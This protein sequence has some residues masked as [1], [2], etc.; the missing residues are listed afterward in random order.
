METDHISRLLT[1]DPLMCY[2]DM[3]VCST[4]DSDQ[5]GE[6]LV[7]M[8]VDEIGE[9]FDPHGQKPQHTEFTNFMNKHCSQ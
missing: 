6:H 1:R 4:H 3:V 9:Y 2:Y 5:P 8:Y 7:A